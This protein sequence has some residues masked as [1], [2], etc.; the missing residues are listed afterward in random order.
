MNLIH[1]V[2]QTQWGISRKQ[3]YS[4][5]GMIQVSHMQTEFSSAY[6]DLEWAEKDKS[7]RL[8]SEGHQQRVHTMHLYE[9]SY[10]D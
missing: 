1:G 10:S 3:T 6:V 2:H 4:G 5:A 7:P 9:Y 8:L